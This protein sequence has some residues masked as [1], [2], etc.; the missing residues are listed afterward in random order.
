MRIFTTCIITVLASGISLAAAAE[1]WKWLHGLSEEQAAELVSKIPDQI[2]KGPFK[3][4]I[5]SLRAYKCPEWFRDAKFG[6]WVCY[7]PQS[8]PAVDGWYGRNM[9]ARRLKYHTKKYGHPSKFGFKDFIPQL[10]AE[11]F[12][13]DNLVGQFKEAGAKYFIAMAVHHEN[14]DLWNSKYHRWNAVRM[15]PK[16]DMIGLWRKATLKH[17]LRW[18]VTT[19]LARSLSWFQTAHGKDAGGKYDGNDPEFQDFYHKPYKENSYEYPKNPPATWRLQYYLRVR[20]LIDNYKPD[21]MYFDGAVPFKPDGEPGL[22]LMAHLYNSSIKQ[23]DGENHAV[24]NIKDRIFGIYDDRIATLDLE[25]QQ[26]LEIRDKPWQ[27]DTSIGPWF[28]VKGAKYK[29]AG[30]VIHMLVDIV[31]KNGN[32]L[33]NVP[34]RADGTLD[35]EAR[36]LLKKIGKWTKVN[37]E[38]IY[39]TRPWIIA[40]E[41]TARRSDKRNWG[42]VSD[43]ARTG[44]WN[45]KLAPGEVRFTSKGD[46]TVYAVIAGWPQD[47]KV[48]LSML[49]S[50]DG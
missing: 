14:F 40:G 33:L 30:P 49:A 37:G 41:N 50:K 31:S 10:K 5:K 44:D 20:D 26:L 6:I 45:F 42:G 4:T 29:T 24:M 7:A 46:T 13:P 43:A 38:A 9:Y 19:H 36:V 22:S 39:G 32:L 35:T 34:M 25:R 3:P 12:D 11:K 1:P 17:G 23:H 28:Y 27:N 15:G 18:G 21:L 48:T 16:K 2:E 47:G 8:V